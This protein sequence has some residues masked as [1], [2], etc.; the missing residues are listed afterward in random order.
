MEASGHLY[1]SGTFWTGLGTI[2]T[3]VVGFQAL[4]LWRLG[5]PRRRLVYTLEVRSLLPRGLPQLVANSLKIVHG[6]TALT[7]PRLVVLSVES[8]ARLD[9]TSADFDQ[10]EPLV[11]DLGTPIVSVLDV[12]PDGVDAPIAMPMP[13]DRTIEIPKRLIRKGPLVDVQLLVE[14]EPKLRV[15]HRIV[16][17]V[18]KDKAADERRSTYLT[19][20]LGIGFI[21]AVAVVIGISS[22]GGFYSVL[23]ALVLVSGAA[24]LLWAAGAVLDW[25]QS[26]ILSVISRLRV[27]ESAGH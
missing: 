24:A 17:T 22:G 18:V 16:N 6:T 5:A 12:S 23:I 19:R 1:A 20:T 14:G 8:R 11:F 9:I 7:D 4:I 25:L 2:A 26:R 27:T 21:L 10:D 15:A 13:G 3:I